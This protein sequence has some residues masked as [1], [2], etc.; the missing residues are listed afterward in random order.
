MNVTVSG[1]ESFLADRGVLSVWAVC[2]ACGPEDRMCLPDFDRENGDT[3]YGNRALYTLPVTSEYRGSL[4]HHHS[5]VPIVCST[6]LY[7]YR[8]YCTTCLSSFIAIVLVKLMNHE[9]ANLMLILRSV[10]LQT[11][12]SLSLSVN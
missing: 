8:N 12:R 7:M 5:L 10:K 4:F 11:S 9:E 6:I 2:D 3:R 1:C